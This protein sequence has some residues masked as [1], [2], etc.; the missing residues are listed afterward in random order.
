MIEQYIDVPEDS[1]DDDHF[2]GQIGGLMSAMMTAY[3]N[4]RVRVKVTLYQIGLVENR[5]VE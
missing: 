5:K 2:M 1:A 3:P 4:K